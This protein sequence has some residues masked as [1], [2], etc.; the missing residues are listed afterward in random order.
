MA[1][2]HPVFEQQEQEVVSLAVDHA[3][4]EN[5]EQRQT[6]LPEDSLLG[7][8][9][10]GDDIGPAPERL[11]DDTGRDAFTT[12][13]KEGD[14]AY[15]R[16]SSRRRVLGWVAAGAGLGALG[17][18][19]GAAA[20]ISKATASSSVNAAATALIA[21]SER[22]QVIPL[23]LVQGSLTPS[24]PH[25]RPHGKSLRIAV[26]DVASSRQQ[27]FADGTGAYQEGRVVNIS[28]ANRKASAV[29]TWSIPLAGIRRAV[30]FN[31]V[32][33]GSLQ[34]VFTGYNEDRSPGNTNPIT[35][36]SRQQFLEISTGNGNRKKII[37]SEK[38]DLV[39]IPRGSQS[40][41]TNST[42]IP[43]QR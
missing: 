30:R 36:I 39:V 26:Q 21:N 18:V 12:D 9:A 34:G 28:G 43:S 22:I 7:M 23:K 13:L 8:A 19:S 24:K 11:S 27:K 41:T 17:V 2:E 37:W 3:Q 1:Y 15:S 5:P 29:F 4:H 10:G 33:C 16:S 32:P 25:C 38:K 14:I 31:L 20:A 40:S 35:R 42:P 6:D